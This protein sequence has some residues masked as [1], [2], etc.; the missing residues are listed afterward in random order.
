[1]RH[2]QWLE[3][4][5]NNAEAAV[6]KWLQATDF[7]QAAPV[8]K[9]TLSLIIRHKGID[10]D[11]AALFAHLLAKCDLALGHLEQANES[12]QLAQQY[13][14]PLAE[15][16][17][18]FLARVLED[19]AR[20]LHEQW[21]RKRKV[22]DMNTNMDV[23]MRS[24]DLE[25]VFLTLE[26]SLYL[27]ERDLLL[28]LSHQILDPNLSCEEVAQLEIQYERQLSLS[29]DR[30]M[31]LPF[32]FIVKKEEESSLVQQE[33]RHARK[34][35]TVVVASSSSRS[36]SKT[37]PKR[38][39]SAEEETDPGDENRHPNSGKSSRSKSDDEEMVGAE[40]DDN[41]IQI[42]DDDP[43]PTTIHYSVDQKM[44]RSVFSYNYHKNIDL[45][46]Q[47]DD[48]IRIYELMTNVLIDN[49]QVKEA[50]ICAKF[51]RKSSD[52]FS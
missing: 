48:V 1:M 21:R 20:S 31:K 25:A 10:C 50:E 4:R 38:R 26:R 18:I 36:Q 45:L 46:L 52:Q 2:T 14:E 39:P 42:Q 34:P 9:E 19:Q 49:Q 16:E 28:S 8:A 13:Y 41:Q 35:S 32:R 5:I 6:I 47:S 15:S 30:K 33:N 23:T 29:L 11:D 7:R 44:P 12:L 27:F 22:I 40:N 37:P 24:V 17:P 3:G 43:I 51:I